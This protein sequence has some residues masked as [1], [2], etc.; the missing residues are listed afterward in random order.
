MQRLFAVVSVAVTFAQAFWVAFI[1]DSTLATNLKSDRPSIFTK[2]IN[3]KGNHLK[4]YNHIVFIWGA[5]H[6]N[7]SYPEGPLAIHRKLQ[8]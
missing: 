3:V 7:I 5:C 6:T 4:L 2:R 1:C 8:W